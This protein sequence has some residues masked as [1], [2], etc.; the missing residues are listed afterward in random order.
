VCTAYAT[1]SDGVETCTTQ[2]WVESYVVTPDQQAQLNLLTN[3][4]FDSEMFT[5]FFMGTLMLFATGFAVGIIISQ[6]RKM[7]R[8]V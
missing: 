1:G 5:T 3:G 8:G 6:I 7:R 4:G 2:A